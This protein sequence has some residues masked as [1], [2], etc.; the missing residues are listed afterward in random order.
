M[1]MRL[2]YSGLRKFGVKLKLKNSQVK[3]SIRTLSDRQN[4]IRRRKPT[5]VEIE[6]LNQIFEK[7][8]KEQEKRQR[9]EERS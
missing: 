6:E 7:I 3:K 2:C 1:A 5:A 4:A 9:L 8:D